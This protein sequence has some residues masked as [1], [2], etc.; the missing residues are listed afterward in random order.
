MKTIRRLYFYAVAFISIEVVLWGVIGLLRSI[1]DASQVVDSAS[2][3]AQALSLILVGVPIFLFHWLW[4]QRASAKD[5]EERSSTV[6]AVFLYG[7][8]LGTLIPVVQNTLALI[9][10]TFLSAANLYTY[11]AIVGGSQTWVD[12]LIAIVINLLIAAYFWN[13][14][15]GEWRALAET[16]NFAEIRRL[17]RFV[18]MLY[19][20]LMTVYGAQ[21]AL[22]FAF[23]LSTGDVLGAIG[24]ET[25]VNAIALLVIGAP[26]WF[27]SWRILQDGLADSAERESYL[28]LGILYLLSLGGVIIVLTAGGNL[29]YMILMQVFG[30][31][32][33]W[34]EFVQDIGGPISI[35]VPFGVIWAY[36]GKWLSQQ[37]TFDENAP[38]RAGKQRLYFYI[39]SL[40]G[41]AGTFTAVATLVSVVID[42]A[43]GSA[44]LGSGGFRSPVSGALAALAVGLPLWLMTWRP[45]QAQ[46]LEEGTIGDHARRS[47]I[48]KFYLYLVLFASVIG[49]MVSAGGLIFTLINAALGGETGD[50][51]DA[52]LDTLQILILFVL[53]LLYHLSA[54]RKDSTARADVLAEKQAQFRVLIFDHDGKFGESMK[55]AFARRA[56]KVQL[57]V[58]NVEDGIPADAQ[59]DAIVL[60]GSLAV[61]TP[62]KVRAWIHSFRGNRL[63]VNDEAAGVFWMNDFGQAA[64]SAKAM[65][66]GQDIRPQSSRRMTSVWTYVAY[67]FAVLFACQLLFMLIMFGVSLVTGF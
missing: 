33:T 16:E 7:I 13:I 31:D 29:I 11:R 48:R 19:G 15:K 9:D 53:L 34:A 66:E 37:F 46:A 2:T 12:N 59:A 61:N 1:F 20:L 50:F 10:R 51:T 41:L 14:L 40:L 57:R 4:A 28:R 63:V 45:M 21:Q 18:W 52:I 47:V 30:E 55:A 17:Y 39:L 62:E 67:A 8:L 65:A 32:R 6:R 24:R 27:F 56:P 5:D 60:P 38:R 43:A 22:S 3:L 35:G 64:D 23:T 25:I 49:G 44:Y 58:V 42:L 36:Y 54:L 26:I